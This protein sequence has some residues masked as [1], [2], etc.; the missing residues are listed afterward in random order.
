MGY[1]ERNL[2]P[3][4]EIVHRARLHWMLFLKPLAW[5][6]GAIALYVIAGRLLPY[7]PAGAQGVGQTVR[8]VGGLIV[9][10]LAFFQTVSAVLT[11]KSSEFA[12]TN[13]RLIVKVG[14]I[15]RESLETMLS[16]VE[17]LDV[18]QTLPG[19]LLNYGTI[20]IRGMGGH[21]KAFSNISNPM[22][23]RSAVYREVEAGRR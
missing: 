9:F 20:V 7:L 6:A 12:V 17:G 1:V 19:R 5:W 14:L 21:V 18:N 10:A 13:R 3:D 16:R 4:E 2:E 22:E 11:Y 23:L 15:R 8:M